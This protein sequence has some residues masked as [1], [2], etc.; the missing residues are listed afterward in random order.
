MYGTGSNLALVYGTISV[1][2]FNILS[3]NIYTTQDY[4]NLLQS[5]VKDKK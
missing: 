2:A 5:E 4:L 1:L 3:V